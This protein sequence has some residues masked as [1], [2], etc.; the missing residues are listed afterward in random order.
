MESS[1]V[2]G[3]GAGAAAATS[4]L[5]TRAPATPQQRPSAHRGHKW[6]LEVIRTTTWTYRVVVASYSRCWLQTSDLRLPRVSERH[7]G[8]KT[9]RVSP[10]ALSSVWSRRSPKLL[11][12]PTPSRSHVAHGQEGEVRRQGTCQERLWA[13][14]TQPAQLTRACA[15]VLIPGQVQQGDRGARRQCG[16]Q[17]AHD[18]PQGTRRLAARCWRGTAGHA[19]RRATAAAKP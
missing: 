18:D 9:R 13:T 1:R 11:P 3:A 16:L 17:P 6:R 10:F 2:A 19:R 12:L 4:R 5:I 8:I 7:F 14:A 15:A